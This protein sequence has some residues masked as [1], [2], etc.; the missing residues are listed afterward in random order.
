MTRWC[1]ARSSL[2]RGLRA[3]AALAAG[4]LTSA[5]ALAGSRPAP[6]QSQ[7]SIVPQRIARPAGSPPEVSAYALRVADSLP[8]YAPRSRVTGTLRLWGHGSPK[9]DFM[10]NLLRRWEADF[11]RYQPGVRIVDDMYGTASAVGALYTGA[12]DLAILGEEVSPA[13]EK[14]FER[15]RHYAPTI[16]EIAT[17][18]VDVNYYDYAHMVFV[19]RANPLSR[20]TLP[21]L[22]RILGA[23]PAGGRPRP[24][25]TW[26]ELGVGGA[27]EA[28]RIQPYSWRFDQDFGLF[29]RARVLGGSNRFNPDVRQFIT[30]DRPDGTIDDRGE[31][32][33]Q[34]LARDPDGIAISNIRFANPSVKMLALAATS[35]GPYV[36]PSVRTLISRQYPLTRIIPAVV[37]VPPGQ[38]MA[39]AVA[40][41]LRFILSRDGQRALVEESG[42]LPLGPK[43]VRAELREL[44]TLS[45]CRV[46]AGRCRPGS[47]DWHAQEPV[48]GPGR[49]LDGVIRVWG[50]PDFRTLGR[51]WAERFR[52]SHP[53][54]RVALHMTGND[55]GMAGLYTGEADV[56]LLGRAATDSEVQAFEWVFR[57]PPRCLEI[58]PVRVYFNSGPGAQPLARAFLHAIASRTGPGP[59]GH[60][61]AAAR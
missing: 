58:P 39:P 13:A 9:H 60:P 49:P 51:K 10:G 21:Q 8:P 3:S 12:G 2:F 56:A 31:Q 50:N 43:Y 27:W 54:D 55:T 46:P 36:L 45:R 20:I 35:S 52:A 28:R 1:D 32:I 47:R 57:H 6:A 41:F 37:D 14:A 17:G 7:P 18:S 30:Y 5:G 19:N 29:L 33:L 34:A 26:G 22:A 16:L 48:S 25:R 24:I 15:E 53:R 59:E 23:A 42:Y 40:E 44:E 38:A 11:H 4:L 61:C